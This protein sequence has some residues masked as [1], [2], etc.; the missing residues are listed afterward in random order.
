M[1]LINQEKSE[2]LVT[3]TYTDKRVRDKD[4][5]VRWVSKVRWID[6]LEPA[7]IFLCSS[8]TIATGGSTDI[9]L[10]P[11]LGKKTILMELQKQNSDV[12]VL[13]GEYF[14]RLIIITIDLDTFK[15]SAT[16]FKRDILL[17][18]N[19]ERAVAAQTGI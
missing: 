4:G 12:I 1:R 2:Y 13:S 18:Q 6:N 10:P 14:Y 15:I 5:A 9:H 8:S 3:R 16:L 11:D 19:F 7:H 17:F